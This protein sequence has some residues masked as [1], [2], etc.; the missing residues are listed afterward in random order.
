MPFDK[1]TQLLLCAAVDY[2]LQPAANSLSKG[3]EMSVYFVVNFACVLTF[4]FSE[5]NVNPENA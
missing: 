4:C 2:N 5:L 1:L 3:T